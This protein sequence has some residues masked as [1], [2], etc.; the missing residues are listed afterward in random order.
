VSTSLKAVR[1]PLEASFA[2][3][4]GTASPELDVRWDVALTLAEVSKIA[5]EEPADQIVKLKELGAREVTPIIMGSSEGVVASDSKALVIAFRGTKGFADMLT[6]IKVFGTDV[7]GGV[8]HSGFFQAVEAIYNDALGAAVQQ[9]ARQ[10]TIWVTGHSLGGAMAAGFT[11]KAAQ[12]QAMRPVGVITFGQ[13]LV[14]S[15]ALCQFMLDEFRGDYVR[16]VND[17]DRI[18]RVLRPYRHAGARVFFH[19]GS[20]KLREPMVAFSAQAD[21]STS[22]SAVIA[23]EEL[24]ELQLL[25]EV[26]LAEFEEEIRRASP[27]GSTGA[28]SAAPG[29][30]AAAW[31]DPFTFHYMEEYLK[32]LL[33]IGQ[34]HWK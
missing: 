33:Q 12:E 21:S 3:L 7:S 22:G 29:A 13:P 30:F 34:L 20:Y 26:E 10:K 2:A 25:S 28:P 15:D 17:G 19:Q 6:D 9:G 16:F 11:F 31:W 23:E 8:M 18:A 4:S 32:N 14:M 27:P 1:P 5:Y 24:S